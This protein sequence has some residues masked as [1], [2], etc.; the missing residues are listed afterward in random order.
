M[1]CLSLASRRI[2]VNPLVSSISTPD[3]SPLDLLQGQRL[4]VILGEI[5]QSFRPPW[6]YAWLLQ[7]TWFLSDIILEFQPISSGSAISST[8]CRI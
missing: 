7:V 3:E 6:N 8:G 4:C 5:L 1:S 2:Q